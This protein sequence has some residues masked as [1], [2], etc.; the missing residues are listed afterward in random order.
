M[1]MAHVGASLR[2]LQ[3]GGGDSVER[4]LRRCMENA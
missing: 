2:L 1:L 4:G 3:S